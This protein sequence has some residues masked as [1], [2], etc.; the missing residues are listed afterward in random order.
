M[1]VCILTMHRVVNYGSFMQGYALKRTI[2]A[3]GHH[4]EFRDFHAGKPRHLGNK[5]TKPS[6][7]SKFY[8]I[9]KK[10][11]NISVTLNRRDFIKKLNRCFK[12]V[13]WPLLEVS[14][15]YNYD[16]RADA[17]IIGS[18]EV[19]NYTQ[20]HGF[21]YVPCLFG[22]EIDAPIIASYAASAGYANWGDV[23]RDGMCEALANGFKHMTRIAVRD[24]NTRKL[25]EHCTG[26]S[27]TMVI[28]PTLIYDFSDDIPKHP[29]L[30]PGYV[31]VYAYEGRMESKSEVKVIK[32][33]AHKEK[34]R[35]VSAGF[36]HEWCDENVVVTPF[37]LLRVFADAAYVVTDTFHGSIFAL[38][39][40]RKFSTL[41]RNTSQ[42]GSNTNK[43]RFLLEQ[44]GME[45][46]I[47]NDINQL[48]RV[49]KEPA[50][51]DEFHTRLSTL[52]NSSRA[53]L[54]LIF[55][56]N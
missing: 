36:F 21:G 51:Y 52:Q 27:P 3:M 37:E 25:V 55:S 22:H 14:T 34:L 41:I 12:D 13:C 9:H 30:K 46:R 16:L 18:D 49:L 56:K 35:V 31:L 26:K 28:D 47:L 2:E 15:S 8:K 40:K 24:E 39:S 45:S 29:V 10:I 33:F 53:Y 43:V 20:N 50:P 48:S 1:K 6:L 54:N 44:F 5:I 7:L 17:M 23:K 11:I 4:V 42:W 19:F 32:D 38:K